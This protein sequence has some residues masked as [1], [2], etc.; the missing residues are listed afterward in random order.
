M[1]GL[2]REDVAAERS[3]AEPSMSKVARWVVAQV[4][5]PRPFARG[6]TRTRIFPFA[7]VA[8]LAELSSALPPGPRSALDIWI[9]LGLLAACALAVR[10]PWDRMPNGLTVLVPLLFEASVLW[11]RLGQGGVNTGVG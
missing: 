7:V 2:T 5:A 4:G 11:L 10:A 9:S 1:Q 8:V 6:S 3:L